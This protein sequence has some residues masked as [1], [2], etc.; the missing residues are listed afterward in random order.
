MTVTTTVASYPVDAT[1]VD[2]RLRLRLLATTDLHAHLFSYNYYANRPDHAVGLAR[3]V[4]PIMQARRESINCLLVDNGDTFQGAPLGDA[5]LSD[6]MP[7]TRPHP[8]IAAMN[9]LGYDAATLGNHDFDHGV[10]ALERLIASA[11]HPIVAAN[12]R[13]ADGGTHFVAPHCMIERGMID[14]QGALRMIR[15]G[16][17][18]AL[19][20]QTMQWVRPQIAGRL[21]IAPIVPTILHEVTQMRAAGADLVVVLAHSG[22]GRADA[23][24]GDEN[25]ALALARLDG[26]DAVVAGH[27]HHVFPAPMIPLGSSDHAPI[28]QP[29]FFGSHLGQI[30][31]ELRPCKRG[32]I[33]RD[34]QQHWKVVTADARLRYADEADAAQRRS[35]R[36]KLYRLPHFRAELARGHRLTRAYSARPLG[37][38][39]VPLET[40]FSLLAPCMATQLIADAQR[41]AI[42][43]IIAGDSALAGLPLLSCTTPFKAGGRSG[44]LAYADVPQG[45]L[46]LRHAADI[47]PYANGLTLLRATGAQI[48]LWLERAASAY[49]QIEP[50]RH[51]DAPPQRLLD[52]DFASYNFDRM[53]GLRYR[54]DL[55][56]PARTNAEGDI[57]RDGV[58]RIRDLRRDNGAPVADEDVFLVVTNSYRA[59]GGGHFPDAARCETVYL[60]PHPV[61]DVIAGYIAAMRG[62]VAPTISGG[63]RFMPLGGVPVIYDTGPAAAAH[64]DR[65]A[66]LGLAPIGLSETGFAQY[67]LHL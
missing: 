25:V 63:F 1:G 42:A 9:G 30:D 44:P 5:A 46:L 54:I 38:S 3:L 13:R 16:I 27:T 33:D 37:R 56:Q 49:L 17:T 48:R 43:P 29:G 12:V 10:D 6:L 41:A 34:A 61:R 11:R 40:Y 58:G 2:V 65:L 21:E 14:N 67:M 32:A 57:I 18:G 45:P 47:Y 62:A 52:Y 7:A 22:L 31:L 23:A 55:R 66:Q 26:V 60:S 19:P 35:L 51:P 4:A 39:A 64:A 28:V 15:I 36:R 50:I 24:P 59:A 53:D 8:M 20:P